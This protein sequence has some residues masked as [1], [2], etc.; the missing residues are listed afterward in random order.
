MKILSIDGGGVKGLYSLYVLKQIELSYCHSNDS[1]IDHF[2]II[3]GTSIGA[4]IALAIS[5]GKRVDDII[6]F[7]ETHLNTLPSMNTRLEVLYYN[8]RQLTSYKYESKALKVALT[9][10][11][12]TKKMTELKKQVC[13]PSFN[14]TTMKNVVFNNTFDLSFVDVSMASCAAPSYFESYKI[15]DGYYVDGGVWANNPTSLG[16]LYVVNNYD[17]ESFDVLS[18]CNIKQKYNSS[19]LT[20]IISL[21]TE[22]DVSA[23][24]NVC[25]TLCKKMNSHMTRVECNNYSGTIMLD[26]ID[27][28]SIQVLKKL[29]QRDGLECM[30]ETY[31]LDRFFQ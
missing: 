26:D 8:M 22:S 29:G 13:I 25:L 10:L 23:D 7:F 28:K 21:F 3:C 15:G 5:I 9:T 11:F 20:S 18:I 2:D 24:Y 14:T 30:K 31:N 16:I 1:L 6:T 19:S 27:T 12:G 17:N 4:I